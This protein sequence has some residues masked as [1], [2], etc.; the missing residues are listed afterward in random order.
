MKRILC[1]IKDLKYIYR[2]TIIGFKNLIRWFP[3]IW[4]DRQWDHIYIYK[5]FQ[6]KLSLTEK[7]LRYNGIHV[8]AKRDADKIKTCVIL[9]D[10]LLKDDY[11]DMAFKRHY[12]K[13]GMPELRT[14]K[15]ENENFSRLHVVYDGVK[16][17]EDDKKERKE[18]H[19]AWEHEKYLRE[20]DLDLLFKIMRKHIQGWWD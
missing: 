12:E 6:K 5:I 18:F 4:N 3:I 2:D 7:Y 14:E 16:T 15:T 11:H 9:L 17:E 19:S 1:K 10:R 13:W 8:D 20:Q